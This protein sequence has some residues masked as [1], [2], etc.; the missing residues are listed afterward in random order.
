MKRFNIF[1]FI[2]FAFAFV[3]SINAQIATIDS[4]Y[5]VFN[6]TSKTPEMRLEAYDKLFLYLSDGNLNKSMQSKDFFNLLDKLYLWSDTAIELNTKS[7]KS[8]NQGKIYFLK[9]TY[10]MI[11]DNQSVDCG[12]LKVALDFCI[13]EK[14]NYY[15]NAILDTLIRYDCKDISKQKISEFILDLNKEDLSDKDRLNLYLSMSRFTE[16]DSIRPILIEG[17]PSVL[18]S[19]DLKNIK[20]WSFYSELLENLD[21]EISMPLFDSIKRTLDV[22]ESRDKLI[23]MF[24]TLG[25]FYMRNEKYP[26]ALEAF[27]KALRLSEELS[28]EIENLEMVWVWIGEIHSKIENFQEAQTYTLKGLEIAKRKEGLTRVASLYLSMASVKSDMGEAQEALKYI[29][30]AVGLMVSKVDE[31][32]ACEQCMNYALIVKSKV[33]NGLGDYQ[34]AL[35]QLLQVEPF[36]VNNL[37]SE[38]QP[39]L[40]QEMGRAYMGLGEFK[41]AISSID[42]AKSYSNS[43]LLE[44]KHNYEIL[45]QSYRGLGN[46][47]K[48]LEAFEVFVAAE[49]SITKLRNSQKT[50]RLEL[51]NAFNQQRLKDSLVVQKSALDKELVEKK[52]GK[53]K[54]YR[55]LIIGAAILALLAALGLYN[56]LN[57][58]KKTQRVL[59]EKNRVIEAEKERAKSSERAKHQFLANMSHEIR[60][61]MNAIKGMTDILLRRNP[62]KEQLDYLQAIKESLNSLLVIIDDVLDLS[63]IESGKIELEKMPFSISEEVYKVVQ[64][65]KFKAE[66][67]GIELIVDFRKD[68]P[69]VK[70]DSVRLRQVLL[71]L[72]G[73]GIKFT[74]V[75][76]IVIK[77]EPESE[78]GEETLQVHFSI[79]DTGIGIE[80]DK[81]ETV[82][83][84]FEQAQ[85]DTSRKFGGTGLGLSIAKKIIKQHGGDI[86]VNSKKGEGSTFHF[87]IP[88]SPCLKP[89]L[90]NGKGHF[91]NLNVAKA[92]LEGVKILLVEDN[93]FNAVVAKEELE[94]SL[95][96]ITVVIAENGKKALEKL[97]MEVFDV[98]L[99]DVQMPVMNGLEC[100]Q[101]IR[102][103]KNSTNCIPIIAMTANVLKEEVLRCYE[104]GMNDF[105]PKPFEV[106]DLLQKIY[107]VTSENRKILK[108]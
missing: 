75:G 59:K 35:D 31:D 105:V 89:S 76:K 106:A 104:A 36:Y 74:S 62:K 103:M 102:K 107:K 88:Y 63:K 5:Q 25:E 3:N 9:G 54:T 20:L 23:P 15:L 79:T 18:S 93:A 41:Q 37:Y 98:V 47:K 6:D 8:Y 55:K 82:F 43:N 108:S 70:G 12:Y 95:Q 96:S 87:V 72:V 29:D 92:Q 101:T 80:D 77:V 64:I 45:A 53:E 14:D 67:K 28:F 94:D 16:N 49:D 97:K 11:K 65:M 2:V 73:N 57:F 10:L 44:N 30:S 21:S 69:M 68:I 91:N 13:K 22:T 56:R 60:T 52:L 86:W 81:L 99:M 83:K 26:E 4:L 58:I 39:F 42:K 40:Y 24:T 90:L 27:Q 61:P 85:T 33:Y 38:V 78:V 46:Y 66:E 17:I 1:L 84:S 51:E 50:M 32:K 100:T 7:L 48:S 19:K 71:N 34:K